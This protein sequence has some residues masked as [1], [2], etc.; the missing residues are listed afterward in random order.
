M[1]P[2]LTWGQKQRHQ[3][4][5]ASLTQEANAAWRERFRRRRGPPPRIERARPA[6]VGEE[7][8][9]FRVLDTVAGL[10]GREVAHRI[11]N[12]LSAGLRLSAKPMCLP[13][14]FARALGLAP[15]S[16]RWNGGRPQ[17]RPHIKS[18]PCS[19]A[20]GATLTNQGAF[21]SV[22]RNALSPANK[23]L[24]DS[25]LILTPAPHPSTSGA[26]QHAAVR[27]S[28][29]QSADAHGHPPLLAICLSVSG[30]ERR[31][32]RGPKRA[33]LKASAS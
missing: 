33:N 2:Q 16:Q 11:R 30:K 22:Q 31:D 1:N 15:E 9:R 5:L 24:P 14:A 18:L 6:A 19:R 8:E 4:L 12:V 17:L 3:E 27:L 29:S 26:N 23:F 7:R 32:P 25:C 13:A 10:R 28:F 20:P 21:L